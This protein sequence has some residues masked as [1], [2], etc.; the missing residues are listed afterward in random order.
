MDTVV[1]GALAALAVDA[2]I[3]PLDTIKTRLQAPD[4]SKRF[5]TRRLLFTGLYQGVGTVV[6]ATLPAAGVFF[7]S[8]EGAKSGLAPYLSGS[9]LHMT[10]SSLAEL[11]S[12]AVL[13]PAEIIKQRAQV[14]SKGAAAAAASASSYEGGGKP[15]RDTAREV[16]KGQPAGLSDAAKRVGDRA[17]NETAVGRTAKA[18]SQEAAATSAGSQNLVKTFTR[19][20]LAL[21]GRN[22]PFTAVQFPLYEKFRAVLSERWNV[23]TLS[24]TETGEVLQKG[25]ETLDGNESRSSRAA[26]SRPKTRREDIIK[27]GLVASCSAAAAGSIS[28]AL[29]TP[30]DNAKTR[31]MIA[32]PSS[33]DPCVQG[34]TL[35]TMATIFRNEGWRALWRGGLLRSSWTA[36]GAGIYLGSYESG[37]LW[38][39]TR[40]TFEGEAMQQ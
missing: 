34:G 3:Y 2:L 14:A 23:K 35:N 28:A 38:W 32:S 6:V 4:V 9:V 8:Y 19:G 27:P 5:P 39:K 12:C 18:A 30:I 17:L 40:G 29:S 11:A 31:I 15:L 20:Y 26:S 36:L 13:T 21:A 1:A 24:D 37:R 33:P 7:T 16:T 25:K 22:L 10:S